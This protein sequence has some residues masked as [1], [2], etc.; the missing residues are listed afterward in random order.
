MKSSISQL[1]RLMVTVSIIEEAHGHADTDFI[2]NRLER[3][4]RWRNIP[5]P[6]TDGARKRLL[7]RDIQTIS[8]IMY[9]DIKN[10]RNK[11]YI[12]V[13]RDECAPLD[14]EKLFSDFDLLTAVQ[15]D[16]KINSF[17]YPD[18]HR[19]KGVSNLY[20]LLMAA[21]KRETVSFSYKLVRHGNKEAK[22]EVEPYFLKENQQRWYLIG[23]T[24]GKIKLFGLD[25]ISDLEFT[26]VTYKYDSSISASDMFDDSYGIW[27]APEI[28]VEKIELRFSQLDGEFLKGVPLH[29][30]QR[31]LVD[32]ENEFR[33]ELN[34]RITN[35]F[36]MALLSRANSLEVISPL[37]LR[38]RIKNICET[39]A[40]RNN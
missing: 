27:N 10:V 32:N 24:D 14:F 28:P 39:C 34:L 1:L 29:H 2:F 18:H 3:S 33:I 22:Y 4:C 40:K 8:E 9:I 17:I 16:T 19:G 31:I 13:N 35:D 20:P 36:V 37:H 5:Y 26:G 25:R 15:P 23:K 7:Q 11:G 38:E 30:S 12:I 21:K 6:S